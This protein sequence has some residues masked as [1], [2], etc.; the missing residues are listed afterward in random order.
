MFC[1]GSSDDHRN[2]RVDRLAG[3]RIGIGHQGGDRRGDMALGDLPLRLRQPGACL[4]HHGALRGDLVLAPGRR[5]HLRELRIGCLGARDGRGQVG[6]LL[7]HRLAAG[8][9]GAQ[10]LLVA[11]E[12][13]GDAIPGREQIG[14]IGLRLGD[15]GVAAAGLQVGEPRLRLRQLA[16]RRIARRQRRPHRP[17]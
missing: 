9:A 11:R 12:V 15:L 6:A 14:Q 7:I 8:G 10:Q 4:L 5:L 16:G 17:G 1:G 13:L 2:A 3:A